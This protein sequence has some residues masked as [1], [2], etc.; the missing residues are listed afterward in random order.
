VD[1]WKCFL[2]LSNNAGVADKSVAEGQPI[3]SDS[4]IRQRYL[5]EG[6]NAGSFSERVV[7]KP[8]NPYGAGWYV[9]RWDS[10]AG[11]GWVQDFDSPNSAY[12]TG[13]M[14]HGDT[15]N[16]NPVDGRADI[17][18]MWVYGKFWSE[19]TGMCV[20]WGGGPAV[21]YIHLLGYPT[22]ERYADGFGVVRQTFQNGSIYWLPPYN[23]NDVQLHDVND[24]RFGPNCDDPLPPPSTPTATFTPT[25]TPTPVPTHT[26][27]PTATPVD[28]DGDGHA[29]PQQMLHIGPVN[30]DHAFDNCPSVSN[31]AQWNR[32]GDP[33]PN[34][35]YIPGEDAT[36]ASSDRY[37]DACD[38][39][40]DNDGRA[41]ADELFAVGCGGAFTD[42]ALAD[43]DGDHLTDGWECANGSDPA[44]PASRFVGAG[45]ADA[46]GDNVYDVVEMRGYGSSG[47]SSDSDG[48]GCGDLVE[49]GSVNGDRALNT[50][51][52]L[53]LD[54]RA[55]W[56]VVTLEPPEAVQDYVLDLNKDGTRMGM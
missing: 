49:V 9:H 18:A 16:H 38:T 14:M 36:L 19:Y 48:D 41:D 17:D 34:G 37:G 29:D 50:T 31:S 42:P 32:D 5:D 3:T 47:G 56:P 12:G 21:Q 10:Y 43:T 33:R 4:S 2:H 8:A 1:P 53:L 23:P 40:A 46:D 20:P 24:Q 51:D 11:S 15:V 6:N 22:S 52:K 28:T 27:T 7:G 35:P 30:T 13:A 45:T 39:D 25:R 54:R 26:P 44:D 55:A